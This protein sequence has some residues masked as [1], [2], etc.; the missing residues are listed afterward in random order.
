MRKYSSGVLCGWLTLAIGFTL[1][2]SAWS[3]ESAADLLGTMY[4]THRDEGIYRAA[5]DG[6]EVK[7]LIPAKF[8][9]GLAVDRARGKIYWTISEGANKVQTA[10]LD[11]GNVQDLVTGLTGT[12]DLT[13]DADA[14]KLYVTLMNEGKI[15]QVG[16]DG[17]QRRDV[18]TGLAAPDE[19]AIDAKHGTLY[20]TCSG[21]SAIQR[22]KIDDWQPTTIITTQGGVFFGLAID[23]VEDQLYC[24]QAGRGM[25]YRAGLDGSGM[26]QV[27]GGLQAP[28]G[29]ALDAENHKLYWTERGK[30]SQA[31][32]D[33]SEVEILVTGKVAQYAS[34]I[35][36]PPKE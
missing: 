32:L 15:I 10:D 9:D 3:E 19:L 1:A 20:W 18:L 36:L 24:V 16:V 17:S 2:A 8:A 11:G 23:P 6:S 28:D 21:S 29:L 25:I 26:R 14:G 12:G 7:L 30:I 13:L 33:G 5:R 4:W 31:N 27:V 22:A 35:V 34:I